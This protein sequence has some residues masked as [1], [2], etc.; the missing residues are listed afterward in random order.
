MSLHGLARVT[1]GVPDVDAVTGFYT[2]FGLTGL[3]DARFATSD[4]GEQLRLVQAPTRRVVEL[5]VGADH[6]DDLDRA[7]ANLSSCGIESAREVD[8]LV[9]IEPVTDVRVIVEVRPAI[10]PVPAAVAPVNAP[11]HSCGSPASSATTGRSTPGAL[12]CALLHPARR[13][14]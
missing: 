2:D 10:T 9:A 4:G 12:R 3:G 11:G 6:A 7:A 5:V 1:I 14:R 13:P 8:W